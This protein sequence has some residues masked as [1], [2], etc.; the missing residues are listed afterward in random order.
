VS[1]TVL[2]YMHELIQFSTTNLPC[3]IH[4]TNKEIKPQKKLRA[5]N[6]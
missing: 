3:Y 6:W 2:C 4:F 5:S 1:D